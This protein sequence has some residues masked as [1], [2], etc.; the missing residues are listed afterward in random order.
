MSDV[1]ICEK[2]TM[3]FPGKY[4]ELRVGNTLRQDFRRAP[5]VDI[6]GDVAVVLAYEDQGRYADIFETETRIMTL[7]RD[8]VAQ[9][10]LHEAGI[11]HSYLEVFLHSFRVLLRELIGKPDQDRV[12]AHIFFVAPLDHLLANL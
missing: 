8:Q 4:H 11:R 2:I 10:K 12:V 1:G 7:A 6:A 5:V 3:P 9:V